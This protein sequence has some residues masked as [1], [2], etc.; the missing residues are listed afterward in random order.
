MATAV[1]IQ[2][3]PDL[4]RLRDGLR[5]GRNADGGWG[6]YAG[7]ASRLEPTCWALLALADAD[8]SVLAG[9]PL[10]DGLLRER[11]DGEVNFAFHA[12]AL[13]VLAAR[14]VSHSAGADVLAGALERAKG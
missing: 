10:D 12:R 9:W 11:K 14:G 3:R 4:S 7:K 1:S 6:Y 8:H 5:A 2:A 13:T